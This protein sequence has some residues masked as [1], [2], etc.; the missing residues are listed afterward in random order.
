MNPS[1]SKGKGQC[2][3]GGGDWLSVK[4][5]DIKVLAR[6]QVQNMSQDI[7]GALQGVV[8]IGSVSGLV[9]ALGSSWGS[10]AKIAVVATAGTVALIAAGA[11]LDRRTNNYIA[12][13]YNPVT[14]AS[15]LST[16]RQVERSTQQTRELTSDK[17][18]FSIIRKETTTQTPRD[19]LFCKC[20]VAVFQIIDPHDYWNI[21]M[22]LNAKTGKTFVSQAAEKDAPAPTSK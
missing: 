5:D 2:E 8:A 18:T 15:E 6:G 7:S 20:D 21:S 1:W 14:P 13:F 19:E 22:F 17:D 12:I 11:Y 4:Y 3:K 16:T 10:G 9:T